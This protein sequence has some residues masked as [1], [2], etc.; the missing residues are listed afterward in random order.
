VNSRTARAT[1]RNPDSKNNNNKQTNKQQKTQNTQ[2]P[3]NKKQKTKQKTEGILE[4][5][6][7][8]KR[9]GTIDAS[10][11]NRIQEMKERISGI[12]DKVEEYHTLVKKNAKSKYL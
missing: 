1:Q 10:F 6:N 2:D 8:G 12:E 5:E 7:L 9:T 3:K 4:V 11:I